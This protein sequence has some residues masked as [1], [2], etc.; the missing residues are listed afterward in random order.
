MA[1]SRINTDKNIFEQILSNPNYDPRT[2]EAQTYYRRQVLGLKGK[3]TF[4]KLLRQA[5]QDVVFADLP[6]NIR[7]IGRMI[8][9]KY[10]AKGRFDL[11]YYDRQP[12]VFIL[13]F[14][15]DGFLGI[16]F[17]YL[18]FKERAYLLNALTKLALDDKF[19]EETRLY[20]SYKILQRTSKYRYFRPCIKRYLTSHV[21]SRYMLIPS[22]HWEVAIFLPIQ[23]FIG[24]D[25]DDIWRDSR[26]QIQKYSINRNNSQSTKI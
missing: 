23:K 8:H 11:P 25:T 20:I 18:P 3:V 22:N 1:S 2:R 14:T 17:H 7:L 16:N 6:A 24:A 26:K 12:L 10:T 21:K 4:E 13:K 9:F 19:D 15:D 5:D